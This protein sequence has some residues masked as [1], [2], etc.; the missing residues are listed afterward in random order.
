MKGT[1]LLFNIKKIDFLV[2]L[3]CLSVD[4]GNNIKLN[5][6]VSSLINQMKNTTGKG[7]QCVQPDACREHAAP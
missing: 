3:K 6:Q 1:V 7:K 4:A 2:S 5:Y